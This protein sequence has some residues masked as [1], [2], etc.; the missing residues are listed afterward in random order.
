MLRHGLES[1]DL[2][3]EAEA[4]I[5]A[6]QRTGRPLGGAAFV[7]RLEEATGRSLARRKPGLECTPGMR[8]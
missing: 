4:A 1:G 7:K 5:E 3:P 8:Q 6:H 2:A